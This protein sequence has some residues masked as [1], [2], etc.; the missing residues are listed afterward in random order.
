MPRHIDESD[1]VIAQFEMCE[2]KVYRDASPLLFLE[3]VS[4]DSRQRTD[5]RSLAM[6]NMSG[7][8]DDNMIHEADS[9]PIIGAGGS[10]SG[11]E[12]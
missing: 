4:I 6:I 3:A 11:S 8:T 2:P 9:H 5:Q 7:R 12:T 1:P 10:R